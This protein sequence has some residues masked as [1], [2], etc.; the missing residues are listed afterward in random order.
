MKMRNIKSRPEL[1]WNVMDVREM[2]YQNEFFDLIIDKS[3]ID[4]MLC[5]NYAYL[6]V[7]QMLKECQRV[8]KVG[9][10]YMAISYGLP[11]NRMFHLQRKHL[12]FDIKTIKVDKEHPDT[13][14]TTA[15]YIYI[16]TK[17]SNLD[18][19]NKDVF[20][21]VLKQIKNEMA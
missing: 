3:T 12:N 8:L 9:G 16:C 7:A 2:N 14:Q 21:E 19:S 18:E 6:N 13:G 20:S 11:E 4:A 17:L 15:H 5:G 10:T 1:K